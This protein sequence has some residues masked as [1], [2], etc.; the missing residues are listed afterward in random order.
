MDN[1]LVESAKQLNKRRRRRQAWT[2]SL[3]ALG[4]VVMLSTVYIMSLPAI[5]KEQN[6]FC[7]AEA[8]AE[9]AFSRASS[10]YSRFFR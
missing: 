9:G 5:T 2:R 3:I 4:C 1:R 10:G 7:G 6:T 8:G